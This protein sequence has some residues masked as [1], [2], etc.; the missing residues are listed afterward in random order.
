[1]VEFTV[2]IPDGGGRIS[3]R[4]E[5][6][7]LLDLRH[8]NVVIQQKDYSCGA[9]SLATVFNYYLNEPVKESEIIH[10]L[11]ELNMKHGTLESVIQRKGFSM[12]DLKMFSESRGVKAVGYRL[13]FDDLANLGVQAIV[14]IIP[15]GYKHFVV[16]RAADKHRVYLADPSFGNYTESIDEFKHD[17][18]GFINVALAFYPKDSD[19]R[20]QPPPLTPQE[21]ERVY[22][23]HQEN[24]SLFDQ[25]L[26][27]RPFIPGEW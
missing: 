23:F 10:T 2:G 9:A 16:F 12:L 22:A 13:D 1:M 6:K 14:P 15:N 21:M 26:P 24:A 8:Q 5:V 17:W 20:V 19:S 25:M 4:V 3:Q 7:S 27:T 18:Y 11:L